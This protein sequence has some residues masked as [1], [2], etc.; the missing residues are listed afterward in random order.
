M[1]ELIDN[2][3]QLCAMLICFI[4]CVRSLAKMRTR[5]WALLTLFYGSFLSG[6]LYWLLYLMLRGENPQF[7]VSEIAWYASYLFLYLVVKVTGG[8]RQK[9][10]RILLPVIAFTAIMCFFFMQWGDYFSNLIAAFLMSLLL[11]QSI[12]G[13]METAK[14]KA[15]AP[16]FRLYLLTLLFCILEYT[17]WTLS[18]FWMGDSLT[19]PYFSVDFLLTACMV[20]ILPA[21][22]NA[23][24]SPTQCNINKNSA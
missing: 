3:I 17:L 5:T 19:N 2:G 20:C 23:A 15:E 16:L 1:I 21:T 11:Y 4:I 14:I 8:E 12:R 13:L 6:L 7:Y 18:C 22:G 24:K 10:V 9:D